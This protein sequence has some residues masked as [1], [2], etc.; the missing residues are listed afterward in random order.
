MKSL[1]VASAPSGATES[2]APDARTMRF[3]YEM[4]LDE[5]AHMIAIERD[6]AEPDRREIE[7]MV[8]KP[9]EGTPATVFY[10]CTPSVFANQY[11]EC[12]AVPFQHVGFAILLVGKDEFAIQ[13]VLTERGALNGGAPVTVGRGARFLP[14]A[15]EV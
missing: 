13:L 6:F 1:K 10:W 3:A 11:A 7:G 5:I 8:R 9:P 4:A 14:D 12:S 15:I 2:S